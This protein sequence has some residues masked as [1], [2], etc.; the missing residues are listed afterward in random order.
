MPDGKGCYLEAMQAVVGGYVECVT[1][2]DGVNLWCNEEAILFNPPLPVNR[3]FRAPGE[4][5]GLSIRGDFFMTRNDHIDAID[6][7][8]ASIE[9]YSRLFDSEDVEAARRFN[10]QRSEARAEYDAASER[11]Y[12]PDEDR[13]P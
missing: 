3:T 8:D 2:V 4:M 9:K 12:D 7:D 1:L 10:E 13:T 5:E 6:I 11:D